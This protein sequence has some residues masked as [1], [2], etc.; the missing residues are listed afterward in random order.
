MHSPVDSSV[1]SSVQGARTYRVATLGVGLIVHLMVCWVVLSIGYLDISPM[2]FLA[3]VVVAVGGFLA[4]GIAV[5]MEWNLRFKDPDMNLSQM[6]WA[7]S[8]VTLTSFFAEQLKPAVI[9]SGLA[10]IVVGANRLSKRQLL[11][12]A[13]YSFGIYLISIFYRDQ[14]FSVSWVSEIVIMLAFGLVLFFGPILHRFETEMMQNVLLS[15]NAELTRALKT[16]RE[17]AVKDEL[18]GLF[19]RRYLIDV[20]SQQK[21]M[22]ERRKDYQFT[23]C[24]VD[25]DHFKRVNDK[26]GHSTGDNV[27][28]S[29]AKILRSE[30]RETDCG[31]RIGGE[32]FILMLGGTD[33]MNALIVSE[34][35]AGKLARLQIS[36]NE[37]DYR[38]TTSIG[39]A[40][41]RQG[42]D[43]SVLMDRADKALYSAKR[44]GRNKVVFADADED[45]SA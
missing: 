5:L 31:A 27:L 33:Q 17:L 38:I 34:R 29:F 2:Q 37:A 35:I 44:T 7:M 6:I 39:I 16:I 43:V 1:H 22:A 30:L 3:L 10:M 20:L 14:Y 8:I 24:F 23:L 40:G 42:E 4:F 12:F 18:T 25:L 45:V 41:F 32:E 26:F 21:A 19:N 11:L 28:I 15:K 13:I 36:N 9:L